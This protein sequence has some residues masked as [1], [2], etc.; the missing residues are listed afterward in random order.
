MGN[1]TIFNFVAF[2]SLIRDPCFPQCFRKGNFIE[3]KANKL[4]KVY[5]FVIIEGKGEN[6]P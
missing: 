1:N 3:N 2:Q 5:F 4:T 6:I